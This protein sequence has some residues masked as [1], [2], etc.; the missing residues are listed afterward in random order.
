MQIMNALFYYF[1]LYFVYIIWIFIFTFF[2]WQVKRWAKDNMFLERNDWFI[3]LDWKF[4]NW[5]TRFMTN[6]QKQ[7]NN[8]ILISNF[9]TGYTHIRFNSMQDLINLLLDIQKLSEYQN[10]SIEELKVIYWRENGEALSRKLANYEELK[11]YKNIPK[12]GYY[13]KFLWTCD[14]FQNLFFSRNS[15]SN[16]S[17]WNK[18]L[19]KLLHQVRHMNSLFIFATQNADELDIKFRRLSTFYV[20]TWSKFSDWFFWYNIYF[21]QNNSA[22]RKIEDDELYK[23]NKA[24]IFFINKFKLNNYIFKINMWFLE[25]K[26]KYNRLKLYKIKFRFNELQFHSKFNC[27]PDYDIYKPWDIYIF[28]DKFYKEEK[29]K[30]NFDKLNIYL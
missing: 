11:Q 30:K 24:P 13:T 16:F 26:R 28:L 21:F 9:Y 29:K 19:L 10:Y 12:D 22:G 8:Y 2:I 23:I 6:L 17:W 15:L 25:L 14:E 7:A 4:W 5:K 1:N 27:D 20:N 18:V 3:I